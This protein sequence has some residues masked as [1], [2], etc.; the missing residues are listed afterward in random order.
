MRRQARVDR[1][2][3]HHKDR[4]P[5]R[6]TVLAGAGPEQAV[7]SL[8][9]SRRDAKWSSSRSLPRLPRRLS[10]W[11]RIARYPLQANQLQES[12]RPKIYDRM[13]SERRQI[14]ERFL[15]EGKARPPGSR[16]SC[17]DLNKIQSEAYGKS[18]RSAA[19]RREGHEDLFP[20]YNNLAAEFHEFTRTRRPQIIIA[21]TPRLSCRRAVTLQVLGGRGPG[22]NRVSVQ[23]SATNA[24][25]AGCSCDLPPCGHSPI[26]CLLGQD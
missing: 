23:P 16:R 4:V 22:W 7:G 24:D 8:V 6:D 9:R 1:D 19:W 10:V 25:N 3:P 2:H 20:G 12:V 5:L 17:A 21:Q 26:M 11:Y 14:A 18:K 13:T 15:S